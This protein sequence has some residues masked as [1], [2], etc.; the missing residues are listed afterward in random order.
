[1]TLLSG[2]SLKRCLS[3]FFEL[4]MNKKSL[5]LE[6]KTTNFFQPHVPAMQEPTQV[7]PKQALPPAQYIGH[8]AAPTLSEPFLFPFFNRV[9]PASRH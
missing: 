5:F 1:L 8:Y 9:A 2:L 6:K 3:L 4:W 7:P